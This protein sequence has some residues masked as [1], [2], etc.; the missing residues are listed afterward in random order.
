MRRDAPHEIADLVEQM[1]RL[2]LFG[3]LCA[4]QDRTLVSSEKDAPDPY[5]PLSRD[6]R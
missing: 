3:F 5:S 6:L 2:T 1:P 4:R